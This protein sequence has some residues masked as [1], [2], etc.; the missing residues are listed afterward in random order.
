MRI[1]KFSITLQMRR[2]AISI[3]S[4]IPE[5]A[6]RESNKE[7]RNFLS[8]SQG[9]FAELETQLILSNKLEYIG[10]QELNKILNLLSDISKMIIGLRKSLQNKQNR[11]YLM[12]NRIFISSLQLTIND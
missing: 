4:N 10:E 6:V 7:F 8:I 1:E 3:P 9:S 5:G 11:R 2:S 12:F